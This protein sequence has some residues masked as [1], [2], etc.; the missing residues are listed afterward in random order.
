MANNST[1]KVDGDDPPRGN[2]RIKLI[3]S[4]VEAA[5]SRASQDYYI[6]S[7]TENYNKQLETIEQEHEEQTQA[8]KSQLEVMKQESGELIRDLKSQ[9]AIGG[10]KKTDQVRERGA[11]EAAEAHKKQLE[12]T[13]QTSKELIRKILDLE[14]QLAESAE[15]KKTEDREGEKKVADAAKVVTA[16]RTRVISLETDLSA[17]RKSYKTIIDRAS[18]ADQ[19]NK[20]L[21]RLTDEARRELV[22]VHEHHKGKL[23][24]A[25][26]QMRKE[27]EELREQHEAELGKVLEDRDKNACVEIG[28]KKRFLTAASAAP[29]FALKRRSATFVELAKLAIKTDTVSDRLFEYKERTIPTADYCKTLKEVSSVIARTGHGG[30]SAN[31]YILAWL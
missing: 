31:F 4:E 9:L 16:S 27:E 23:E 25:V 2:K 18:V 17:S 5:A 1:S 29:K 6:T 30:Q 12:T 21:R 28:F 8:L 19:S 22:Q 3:Q 7:L 10:E 24:R 14:S 13:E 11:T 15:R 20:D 26:V